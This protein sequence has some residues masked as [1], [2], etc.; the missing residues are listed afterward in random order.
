MLADGTKDEMPFE[1]THYDEMRK[2]SISIL[3]ETLKFIRRS[4]RKLQAIMESLEDEFRNYAFI[5]LAKI[6]NI[7]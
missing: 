1:L 3:D 6:K 4:K 7:N 5:I 2:P